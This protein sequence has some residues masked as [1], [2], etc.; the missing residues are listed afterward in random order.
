MTILE[1]QQQSTNVKELS[2]INFNQDYS[3]I[4]VGTKSGY[5]IYN[6]DPFAKCYSKGR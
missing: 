1:E 5:R 2:C 3:C 6:C 4:S